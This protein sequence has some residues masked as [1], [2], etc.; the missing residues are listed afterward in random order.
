MF[1]L[2]ALDLCPNA[3]YKTGSHTNSA[4]ALAEK[5]AD[6]AAIDAQTWRI[7]RA[8]DPV[9]RTLF[10]I[11]ET[12]PV[13]GLPFICSKKFDPF[14]IFRAI[15]HAILNL[16]EKARHALFLKGVIRIDPKRY[17]EMPSLQCEFNN[18]NFTA[19]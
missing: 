4:R 17:I 15:E 13:P 16:E 8:H 12:S 10:V 9:A 6:F 11:G 14:S 1:N 19:V 5:R 3:V 2:A 18:T 7:I